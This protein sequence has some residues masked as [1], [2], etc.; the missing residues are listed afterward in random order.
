M[1]DEIFESEVIL[2]KPAFV[3]GQDSYTPSGQFGC[4]ILK[5]VGPKI[6]DFC[7]RIDML[8]ENFFETIL[9]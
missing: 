1:H 6:Q 7:P 4:G 3:I 9:R 5:M 8:K 2:K